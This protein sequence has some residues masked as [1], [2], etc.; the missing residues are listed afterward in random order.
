M[1]MEPTLKFG[2]IGL[3]TFA[4]RLARQMVQVAQLTAIYDP[5]QEKRESFVAE[6]RYEVEIFEDYQSLLRRGDIDAVAITSPNFTHKELTLGAARAGKHVF[7]EKPMALNVPD[8][9]DMVRACQKAG[10][11]LMIGHKRR[12]RPPWER[13]LQL[14]EELGPVSAVSTTLYHLRD[15][16]VPEWWDQ[17]QTS[18]G[19]LCV[20]GIHVIDWLRGLCGDVVQVR[21]LAAPHQGDRFDF[22][23]TLHVWLEFGSGSIGSLDVSLVFPGLHYR[24]SGGPMIVYRDGSARL[25]PCQ[26]HI[27]LFW[28]HREE[29]ETHKE[30]FKD[31]GHDHAYRRELRDFVHWVKLDRDPC[32]SWKE[33]LR[34][35]EVIEAAHKSAEMQ[36]C[37]LPLP[38]Y[39]DLEDQHMLSDTR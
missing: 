28:R 29:Q 6:E 31:L 17:K 39:P 37:P 11:R 25:V 32:L 9:W 15:P 23:D 1:V 7:C 30:H 18:G 5:V 38:L 27:D 20:A 33:G 2:L 36:G 10:V 4:P 8:C 16:S 13:L 22:P 3:G 14:R 12:L 21:A 24:E 35:V 26:T 19:L 34:C